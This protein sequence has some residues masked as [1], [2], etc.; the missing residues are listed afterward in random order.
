MLMAKKEKTEK[1]ERWPKVVYPILKVFS[2]THPNRP[3]IVLIGEAHY[4]GDS[5]EYLDKLVLA[6]P[7]ADVYIE[8]LRGEIHD[9]DDKSFPWYVT[10]E[11]RASLPIAYYDY[12][13]YDNDSGSM[14]VIRKKFYTCYAQEKYCRYP[15][16]V[17]N[18]V[19]WDGTSHYRRTS[20]TD[21]DIYYDRARFTK[22]KFGKNAH[23]TNRISIAIEIGVLDLIMNIGKMDGNQLLTFILNSE[24]RIGRV[25]QETGRILGKNEFENLVGFVF[26]INEESE[27]LNRFNPYF[28]I[29]G[30][31][32]PERYVPDDNQ[33][34]RDRYI[35]EIGDWRIDELNR[36]MYDIYT[37][38][39]ILTSDR[40]SILYHGAA[41]TEFIHTVLT[42][43]YGYK[44]RKSWMKIVE[45][46]DSGRVEEGEGERHRPNVNLDYPK[47]PSPLNLFS[48]NSNP[49]G[50]HLDVP[51]EVS[52]VI[53]NEQALKNIL[54]DRFTTNLLGSILEFLEGSLLQKYIAY[55][56][57]DRERE[58]K[59]N[60]LKLLIKY[61]KKDPTVRKLPFPI[62]ILGRLEDGQFKFGASFESFNEWR[63]SMGEDPI[64]PVN[65]S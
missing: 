55:K 22:N 20:R 40:R 62:R 30:Y 63:I 24:G 1:K 57:I 12:S 15:N 21:L 5:P 18:T 47:L 7:D 34:S 60:K 36:Y 58:N 14:M 38:A 23:M 35:F 29:T 9:G 31:V 33:F 4:N 16:R 56:V 6:N 45:D 17:F 46:D 51:N 53:L 64:D 28:N 41:H 65:L 54:H 13:G 27:R 10:Y 37:I 3:E 52:S 48:K 42:S 44:V 26:Q 59:P 49:K 25:L 39:L 2:L 32:S 43:L 61:N 8:D 50:K 19:P 11:K